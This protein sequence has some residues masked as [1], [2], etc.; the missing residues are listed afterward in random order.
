MTYGY[1]TYHEI[2][3]DCKDDC[4]SCVTCTHNT[5]EDIEWFRQDEEQSESE[6]S[7]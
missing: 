1:C 5:V 6:D 4:I 2:E 3:C 7:K